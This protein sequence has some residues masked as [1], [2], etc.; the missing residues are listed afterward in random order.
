MTTV[1]EPVA[2][3]ADRDHRSHPAAPSAPPRRRPLGLILVP[4]VA[5]MLM[6]I[7]AGV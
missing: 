1:A 5:L 3:A 2:E 6:S 7:A 4:L